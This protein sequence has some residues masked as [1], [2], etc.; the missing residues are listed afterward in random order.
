[1]S[2]S[3]PRPPPPRARPSAFSCSSS[4][5]G[6]S[7]S[8]CS[9]FCFFLFFFVPLRRVLE[10]ETPISHVVRQDSE[11]SGS[12]VVFSILGSVSQT[13]ESCQ[14]GRPIQTVLSSL[15]KPGR[16]LLRPRCS[17][18]GGKGMPVGNSHSIEQVDEALDHLHFKSN[19]HALR[20]TNERTLSPD[21]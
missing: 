20:D 13:R 18:V 11:H 21:G 9:S 3:Y 2:P 14:S 17:P 8:S 19:T 16:V 10:H 1:M 6:S 5:S 4:S 15:P 12:D 7:S